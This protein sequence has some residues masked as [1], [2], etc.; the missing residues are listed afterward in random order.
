MTTSSAAAEGGAYAANVVATRSAA[1]RL[2]HSGG[3][4]LTTSNR[5]P[6]LTASIHRSTELQPVPAVAPTAVKGETKA[7]IELND[8]AQTPYSAMHMPIAALEYRR[9]VTTS[10]GTTVIE[11]S[12]AVQRYRRTHTSRSTDWAPGVGGPSTWRSRRPCP[13]N[14]SRR[15]V[16]RLAMPHRGH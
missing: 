15:P 9:L 10:P 14:P 3:I 11:A 16:G 6:D 13:C 4:A 5:R 8:I 2:G 1:L 7:R 12:Q